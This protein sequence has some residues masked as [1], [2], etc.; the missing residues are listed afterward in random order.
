ME[1]WLTY[2]RVFFDCDSTLTTIEGI[3]ELARMQGKEAEVAA[4][5]R[6]AMEGKIALETIYARRLRLLR[7]TRGQLRE[8]ASGGAEEP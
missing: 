1:P 6:Q 5:T 2:H 8:V 3:D 4:L 7:P